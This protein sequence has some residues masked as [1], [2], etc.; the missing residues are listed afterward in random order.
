MN[1]LRPLLLIILAAAFAACATAFRD[2]SR[3]VPVSPTDG[4]YI[5]EKGS[6]LALRLGFRN[7]PTYDNENHLHQGGYVD[8]VAFRFNRAGVLAASPGYFPQF[9]P[10]SFITGSLTRLRK[11]VSTW[12]E[13]RALFPTTNW[14]IKQPDGGLLV[15]H[16]IRKIKE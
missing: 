12:P 2:E 8:V 5:L 15:Y 11:G 10:D 16:E 14:V 1:F 7:P 3:Y 13:V 4:Y 9:T 6:P